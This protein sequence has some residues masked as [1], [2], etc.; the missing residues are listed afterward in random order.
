VE[1]HT[2]EQIRLAN[3]ARTQLRRQLKDQVKG[4]TKYSPIKDER[5]VKRPAS[6]YIQF[7]INRQASG[8]FK[9]ISIAERAKLISQE[10]KAL[11]AGE[12]KV[13]A[14]HFSDTSII[15]YVAC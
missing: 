2:V 14:L 8:D 12:K 13:S 10:W 15:L 9:N 6:Q 5:L 11:N 1:S 4:T 3:N 7:S